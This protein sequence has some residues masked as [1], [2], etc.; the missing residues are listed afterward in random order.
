MS[1]YRYYTFSALQW[2]PTCAS[3][4]QTEPHGYCLLIEQIWF[5]AGLRMMEGGNMVSVSEG[6]A[7]RPQGPNPKL[8][9]FFSPFAFF[10]YSVCLQQFVHLSFI[11]FSLLS[12]CLCVLNPLFLNLSPLP[13][14]I[15]PLLFFH[16]SQMPRAGPLVWWLPAGWRTQDA[17]VL[18]THRM[19]N[20]MML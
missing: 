4:S 9:V 11:V 14:P 15:Q 16:G 3:L 7:C 10:F 6:E 19:L 17:G 2:M 18:G 20:N 1:S 8:S 5:T 12:L 13:P